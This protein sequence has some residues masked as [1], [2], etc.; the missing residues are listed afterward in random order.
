MILEFLEQILSFYSVD[1]DKDAMATCS[2]VVWSCP[3]VSRGTDVHLL[4]EFVIF[5]IAPSPKIG[6]T[7]TFNLGGTWYLISW[8]RYRRLPLSPPSHFSLL[9]KITGSFMQVFLYFTHIDQWH[10]QNSKVSGLATP[11]IL[12]AQS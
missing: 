12:T 8:H 4:S 9:Q 5:M 3:L 10:K 6:G 1:S 11:F 2:G 7:N